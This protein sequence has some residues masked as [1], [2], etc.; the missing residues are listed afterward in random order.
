M[1][2]RQCRHG[3]VKVL[4]AGSITFRVFFF[5]LQV[6]A[7]GPSL[8][9]PGMASK[10]FVDGFASGLKNCW[11][12]WTIPLPPLLHDSMHNF[13]RRLGIH[14]RICVGY[15]S[16]APLI[17]GHFFSSGKWFFPCLFFLFGG[18]SEPPLSPLAIRSTS[19]ECTM[20]IALSSQDKAVRLVSAWGWGPM[21]S[22]V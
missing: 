13:D 5:L 8:T 7:T 10:P 2:H 11:L 20:S 1:L 21:N 14:S 17:T 9:T 19:L 6:T 15:H 12:R 4:G 16:P 3:S 18:F 22:R